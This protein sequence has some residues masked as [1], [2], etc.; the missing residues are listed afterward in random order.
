MHRPPVGEITRPTTARAGGAFV[1]ATPCYVDVGRC[2]RRLCDHGAVRTRLEHA[3]ANVSDLASAIEWYTTVLHFEIDATWP[4]E[5]PNYAHFATE[6]GA[7][8]AIQEA[9]GR[10]GRFNFTVDDPD[11]M[12][13][14]LKD[15]VRVVE[16]LFTTE[17]GTRKFTIADPDGNELGFVDHVA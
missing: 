6:S 9:E 1:S 4:T 2:G 16:A 5:R 7:V 13:L 17:Y 12:W 15:R 3:R 11:E 14:R 10:G 8:F